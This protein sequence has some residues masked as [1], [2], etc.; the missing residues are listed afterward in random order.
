LGEK[1]SGNCHQ[2]PSSI[3][4]GVHGETSQKGGEK[5]KEKKKKTEGPLKKCFAV[6]THA[7]RPTRSH[8][9]ALSEL[10]KKSRSAKKSREGLVRLPKSSKGTIGENEGKNL[11]IKTREGSVRSLS[12]K[13]TSDMPSLRGVVEKK[14]KFNGS[15]GR[16]GERDQGP[17]SKGRLV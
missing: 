13:T 9:R 3:V 12:L 7:Y 5:E 16:R 11:E 17:K 15:R 10:K 1:P 14:R 4:A 8:Q 6:G 2:M